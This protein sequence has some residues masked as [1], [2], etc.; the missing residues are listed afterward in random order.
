MIDFSNCE[1]SSRNLQYGGRAGEKKGILYHDN[2]WF[3]KF[4]KNTIG[5]D[6]VNGLSYTTSPLCE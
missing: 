3:L 4:P 1:L 6:N 2:F 5:M